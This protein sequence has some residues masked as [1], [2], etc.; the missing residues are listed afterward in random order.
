LIDD[1]AARGIIAIRPVKG[2]VM[3]YLKG[4]APQAS[5]DAL[6]KILDEKEG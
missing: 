1:L 2:G 4:D 6:K 5:D 3:L